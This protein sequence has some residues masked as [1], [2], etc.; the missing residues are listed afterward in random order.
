MS[1]LYNFIL[2]YWQLIIA[3][4]LAG[5]D[6]LAISLQEEIVSDAYWSRAVPTALGVTAITL[7]ITGLWV[8]ISFK[9]ILIKAFGH[10]VLDEFEQVVFDGFKATIYASAGFFCIVA[11]LNFFFARAAMYNSR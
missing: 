10:E 9:D 11:L 3:L 2:K 4:S 5:F 7:T 6:L 8:T 1:K